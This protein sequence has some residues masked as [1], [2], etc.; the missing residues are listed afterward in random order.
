[1]IAAFISAIKTVP[2][3]EPKMPLSSGDR[4]GDGDDLEAAGLDL[5]E[6]QPIAGCDVERP[7]HARRNRDLALAGG[8]QKGRPPSRLA[9]LER[10]STFMATRMLPM[11][12]QKY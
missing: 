9:L 2:G 10:Y 11:P 12:I 8:H 1:V 4:A 7:P 5:D 6:L 3:G